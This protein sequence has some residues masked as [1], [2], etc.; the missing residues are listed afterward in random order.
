MDGCGCRW[1]F[2]GLYMV[3]GLPLIVFWAIAEWACERLDRFFGNWTDENWG[4]LT[5]W[6]SRHGG[7]AW[8]RRTLIH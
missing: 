2:F 6:A 4:P 8:D 5:H 1:L 3:A 7:E